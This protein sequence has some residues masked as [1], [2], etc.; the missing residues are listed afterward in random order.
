MIAARP[1]D[2]GTTIR[3]LE[4][5]RAGDAAARNL[6][7]ARYLPAL[8]VW[9]RGRVPSQ[10]RDL[11]DTSDLVQ[12]TLIK[13]LHHVEG[14]EPRHE[15]AFLSYLRR[16]LINCIRDELRK[17][18]RAPAVDQLE[19]TIADTEPS[20]LEVLIG[21]EVAERYEAALEGLTPE[22]AEAVLM[23]V[24]LGFTYEQ[25]REAMG[26]SSPDAAR[27][28]VARGLVRLSE[29]IDDPAI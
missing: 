6:L 26:G 21:K 25:I 12:V 20:P 16:I 8:K 10:L 3:L 17:K 13:A 14:F 18:R 4:R 24:E 9:A 7:A 1:P 29:L 15:G 23:R 5:A 11:L 22:Q 2:A 28:L 27:M 19:E